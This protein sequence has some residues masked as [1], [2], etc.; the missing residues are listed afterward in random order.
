MALRLFD[1]LDRQLK[2]FPLQKCL[3]FAQGKNVKR[4]YSTYES[5]DYSKRCALGLLDLGLQPGD[6]IAMVTDINRPEWVL[7]DLAAQRIGVITVPLYATSSPEE[8]KHIAAE[9]EIQYCFA[10]TADLCDQVDPIFT[11]LPHYR[12]TYCFDR[13]SGYPFWEEVL[14]DNVDEARLAYYSDQVQAE[15]LVTYIYTSGTTGLPKGVMLTHGNIGYN[16]QTLCDMIPLNRGER[17]LSFLP[18]SHVFER[19][20]FYLF[21][22]KCLEI[23]FT[24]TDQLGGETGSLQTVKPHFFATVPRLLEKV[25]EKIEA[26]GQ[27]AGGLKNKILQWSIRLTQDFEYDVAPSLGK[28]IQL[29]LADKIVY[30]KWRDALG[31]NVRAIVVGAAAC[32]DKLLRAFCAAGIPIREAYGQTE[33][34]PGLSVNQF[35]QGQAMIGTVGQPIPG[36]EIYLDNSEG[37]FPDGEGEI[38]ASGPGLMK[39]YYLQEEKTRETLFEK[40]GKT[41]LRTGDIARWV[42][43]K[44]GKKFLKI[45]DRKKELIKTSG[46]KYVAPAPIEGYLRENFLIDQAMVVG[47]NKK[48]VSALIVPS[49]EG[50]IKWGKELGLHFQSLEEYLQN[51]KVCQTL[52]NIVDATN[53]RLS[54][55]S[56]I[57][58]FVLLAQPWEME[59]NDGS[60][61]E[62]TPTLKL[63]RRV[64]MDKYRQQIDH[65]YQD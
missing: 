53:E 13:N 39:G 37:L 49:M 31:G 4:T 25:L 5:V 27:E 33:A 61:P 14:K 60:A 19:A 58:K 35:I 32:P 6:R 64:I 17:V 24:A 18:L 54:Q 36:T 1:L 3:N 45:T 10:A 63:K 34:A 29:A 41:W 59:K 20:A 12:R 23:H 47:E 9:A 7:L 43:D 40:D 16:V 38:I 21:L 30:Q 62:L 26:K 55:V 57:K 11:E 44:K 15:D 28:K 65:L 51:D 56:K 2:I 22:E 8:H 52:Q 46:G 48:F 50:L 42:E